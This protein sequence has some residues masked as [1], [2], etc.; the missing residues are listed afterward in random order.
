LNKRSHTWKALIQA[1]VATMPV[2]F[3]LADVVARRADFTKHY[4]EN[5]FVEAKIR[6]SLQILRD[7]GLIEFLGH[8]RYRRLDVEPVFSPL[9]N[10]DLG[11]GYSSG[12]QVARIVIETWAELNR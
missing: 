11:L 2:S 1:A 8:G 5:R 3:S 7:Q 10:E 4:P 12:A 9:I 6:Q